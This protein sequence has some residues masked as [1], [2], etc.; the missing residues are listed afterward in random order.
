MT[1]QTDNSR[2]IDKVKKLLALGTNQGASEGE[3]DNAMRMAHALLA[4]HNL[5][6]MDLVEKSDRIKELFTVWNDKYQTQLAAACAELFFCVVYTQKGGPKDKQVVFIGR[7]DN[8]L[9][10]IHMTQ[11]L[12]KSVNSEASRLKMGNLFKNGA[13]NQIRSRVRDLINSPV[14]EESSDCTSLMVINLH[15]SEK[16]ANEQF[17][18]ELGV[19]LKEAKARK[20]KVNHEYI[21]G[22]IFGKSVSLNLQIK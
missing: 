18:N 10:A 2:I 19:K 20:T 5:T 6:A 16:D 3:R 15:K 14:I 21:Q 4:R 7:K 17:I 11:Y 9:T 1:N 8:V 12:I 13:A 22:Q